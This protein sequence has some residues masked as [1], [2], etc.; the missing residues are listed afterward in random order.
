MKF[1]ILKD[2]ATF[3]FALLKPKFSVQSRQCFVPVLLS[4]KDFK[5][6][7]KCACFPSIRCVFLNLKHASNR[8]RRTG[9]KRFLSFTNGTIFSLTCLPSYSLSRND[10]LSKHALHLHQ[11][12]NTFGTTDLCKS[13]GLPLISGTKPAKCVG[14]KLEWRRKMNGLTEW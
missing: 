5:H 8:C 11:F 2:M 6:S 4:N 12:T 7:M 13:T 3:Y 10:I 9:T 14:C 1:T